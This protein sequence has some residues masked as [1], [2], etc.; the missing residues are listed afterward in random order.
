MLLAIDTGNTETVFAVFAK[1]D[2]L[3]GEW[4]ISTK[5]Q[6]TADEYAV[7][8]T[9]L[10]TLKDINRLDF[11]AAIISSVVPA[12]LFNL[13]KLCRTYFNI[14]PLI[15]G[16]STVNLGMRVLIDQPAEVGAD[17]LVNSIAAYKAYGGPLIIVDFGTATTFDVIDA[18]GNYRGGVIAPGVNLSVEALHMAAAK[19]PRVAITKPDKVIGTNTVGA[20]QSGVFWGYVSMIEGMIGRIRSEFGSDLRVVAT[21]GLAALFEGSIPD[22]DHVDPN[23]T[24]SGLLHIHRLNGRSQ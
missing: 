12:T 10:M 9:H 13:K 5:P 21:G 14:D 15:V 16:E 24:L 18:G 4:R 8:L 2:T 7:W 1:D 22:F 6:R 23:L 20:I 11:S 17:R 3:I 19:L